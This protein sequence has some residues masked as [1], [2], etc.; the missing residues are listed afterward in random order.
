[1]SFVFS[2]TSPREKEAWEETRGKSLVDECCPRAR[3]HS[4]IAYSTEWMRV[5]A[6]SAVLLEGE[7][8]SI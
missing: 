2:V 3:R 5:A 6:K 7:S 4:C 8:G 1:M